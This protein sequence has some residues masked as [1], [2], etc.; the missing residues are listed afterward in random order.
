MSCSRMTSSSS[1]VTICLRQ[2]F[3]SSPALISE[4]IS[5]SRVCSF[6][7]S[8]PYGYG[9]M[10]QVFLKSEGEYLQVE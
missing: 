9:V 10:R 3:N 1:R 2:S 7:M 4:R 5:R 8:A 6:L